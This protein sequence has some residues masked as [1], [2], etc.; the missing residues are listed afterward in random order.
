MKTTRL[1]ITLLSLICLSCECP[2]QDE[3][4]RAH[5]RKSNTGNE[6]C[7]EDLIGTWQCSYNMIIGGM[8]FKQIRF[9]SNGKA[10]I[11]MAEVSNTDWNTET[12]SYAYYGN[13]LRFSKGRTNIS[14]TVKGWLFP[15]LYLYDSFGTYTITQ[16]RVN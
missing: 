12:F 9:M 10:D 2:Y 6:F 11:I 1:L 4:Q 14:L 15:E 5:L 7:A 13:T 8:E 16:R 3:L